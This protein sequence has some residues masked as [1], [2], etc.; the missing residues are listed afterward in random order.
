MYHPNQQLVFRPP[1]YNQLKLLH[2]EDWRLL[3]NPKIETTSTI[4]KYLITESN[5]LMI[6]LPT[7]TM[8]PCIVCITYCCV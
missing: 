5:E 2:E 3:H 4:Y 8:V 7:E 1:Q 6:D